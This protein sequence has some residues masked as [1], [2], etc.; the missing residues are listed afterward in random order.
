MATKKELTLDLILFQGV[1][2]GSDTERNNEK[3]TLELLLP[4]AGVKN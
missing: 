1:L 2:K 3:L 4:E